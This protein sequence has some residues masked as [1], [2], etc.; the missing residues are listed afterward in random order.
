MIIFLLLIWIILSGKISAF[1]VIAACLSVMITIFI[2]KKLFTISPLFLRFNWRWFIFAGHLIKA[3][4]I[5]TYMVLKTIWR[6]PREVKPV[7][8]LLPAQSKNTITQVMQTNCITLTPGTMSMNIHNN[9]ISIHAIS[10]EAIQDIYVIPE[11]K[12]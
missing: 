4:S 6:N 3:M 5:S 11:D 8:A 1:F 9:K 2:D 7:H 12:V 10:D